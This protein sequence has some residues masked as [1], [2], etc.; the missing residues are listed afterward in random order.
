MKLAV[1]GA[2]YVGLVTAACFAEMGHAVSCIDVDAARIESLNQGILPISEPGLQSLV[3]RNSRE[4]RLRFSSRVLDAFPGHA[5][6]FIAVGTPPGADSSADVRQVLEVAR[7]IGL[8]MEDYS[9][10]VCKSTVPVGTA[11]KI[12]EVVHQGLAAQGR[13]APFDVVSNP[14]FLKEGSAVGDFMSPDRVII[15]SDSDKAREIMRELYAPFM[16]TH[17]RMLFMGVREAEM[18]K[19]AANAMLATRIS[20]MNE[21]A[22]LCDKLGVDV[23]SVRLGVGADRRIGY[24][25]IYPGCGYGGSCLPKDVRAL[26]QLAEE[27]TYDPL[28]LRAIDQRNQY[29]KH[30]LFEKIKSRFGK[31]LR[32]HTFAIWGLSFKPETDDLREAPSLDLLRQLIDA[33]AHIKAHDPVAMDAARRQLPAAWFGQGL[34]N[35]VDGHYDAVLQADALVLATEWRIFRNPDLE[36]LARAM[37]QRIIF[38]G[39]NQYD[40]AR[41]RQHGFEYMGI[42]R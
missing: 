12:G 19:Y 6:F 2:G 36:Y 30:V 31:D 1:I 26:I 18:T 38:D 9:V 21:I 25:F 5:V 40:P 28:V 3:V 32:G 22:N 10:I 7:Q 42:G 39:R 27:Q 24:A 13:V 33:G 41:L 29:Q 35:L 23:E 17:E 15:G 34:L 11:Q 20:F 8:H 14:E 4:G 16:R 37:R